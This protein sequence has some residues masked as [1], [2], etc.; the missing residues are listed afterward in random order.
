MN[1]EGLVPSDWQLPASLRRRVGRS[2]G[3]QRL[4]VEGDD[5]LIV[6]H[7]VPCPDDDDRQGIL[8]W[9]NALG[10][11][12]CSNNEPGDEALDQLL[13]RYE[14]RLEGYDQDEIRAHKAAEYM[15]VLEGLAPMCRSANNL[16][17]VLQEARQAAPS[18]EDLIDVRDRAYDLARTMELTY[19]YAKD[20]M[21]VAVVK[22]S[23][24]QA[25]SSDAM[26]RAA[27]RL[28]IMAALFF[29]LATLGS[30]F[31]TTLTDNWSWSQ[32]P[33]PFVCFLVVGLVSGFGLAIFT[34]VGRK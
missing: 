33:I 19:Q 13:S 29:P 26:A 5:M 2:V 24:Q 21:G 12:R 34:T 4:I 8:I 9:R 15:P 16:A 23:E 18:G 28:N 31:G 7:E 1:A 14:K 11:W 17:T 22:Q 25:A 30:V 3:R 20:S 32:S 6:V 10:H 27:H